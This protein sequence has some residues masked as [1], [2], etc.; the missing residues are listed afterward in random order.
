MAQS[1]RAASGEPCGAGGLGAA[2]GSARGSERKRRAS[3]ATSRNST[4]PQLSR[5]TSSRSPCSAEAASV[6]RPAA[7]GPESGPLSRTNIDRPGVLRTSPTV[8]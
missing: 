3:S 8:Q 2:L 1:L 5:I 7:P 6:Q 4:S